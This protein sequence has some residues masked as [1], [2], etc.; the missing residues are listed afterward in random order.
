YSFE[1]S[2][3]FVKQLPKNVTK[4]ELMNHFAAAGQITDINLKFKKN[5]SFRRFAFIGFESEEAANEAFK[6]N[7][8]YI[9][10]SKIIVEQC[11]DLVYL[12]RFVCQSKSI[13]FDWIIFIIKRKKMLMQKVKSKTSNTLLKRKMKFQKEKLDTLMQNPNFIKYLKLN[14]RGTADLVDTLKDKFGDFK[15]EEVKGEESEKVKEEE[16]KEE[17][18]EEEESE[19][20]KEEGSEEEESEPKNQ[21]LANRNISDIEYLQCLI[22]ASAD[23]VAN[24]K[25]KKA[26]KWKTLYTVKVRTRE[27]HT[28][29]EKTGKI[30]TKKLLK[31]FF[32]PLTFSS[33]RIPRKVTSIAYVGFKTER[34][35]KKALE[36]DKSFIGLD[37]NEPHWKVAEH[38]LQKEAE[39]VGDSGKLFV[40]NLWYSITENDLK[41]LFET[42]GPIAEVTLPICKLTQRS[43]GFAHVTFV[44][45]EHAVKAMNELD[46]KDLKGRILHILPSLSNEDEENNK[47]ETSYQKKKKDEQKKNANNWHNWHTLFIGSKTVIDLMSQKDNTSKYEIF[48]DEQGASAAV[49]MAI[50]EAQ[51]VEETKKTLEENGVSL[52]AFSKTNVQRSSQV[53]LVKNLPA[54]TA[55]TELKEVFGKYGNLG[56][57]VLPPSGV[58]AIIEFLNPSE[59]KEA[60][61]ELAYSRFKYLPL[62]LEWAPFEVFTSPAGKISPEKKIEK[63]KKNVEEKSP[64][65]NTTL[66]VKN[67]NFKTDEETLKTHFSKI[68]EVCSV[69]IAKRRMLSQG[70][71]FVQF[72]KTYDADQ[73]L[74]VLQNSI[75][76]GHNLLIKK[77]EKKLVSR[78]SKLSKMVAKPGDPIEPKILIRNIPFQATYKEIKDLFE[79]TGIVKLL[80]LPRKVGSTEHRG[81]GFI[82]FVTMEEA[83]NA[84]TSLGASTHLYGRRLVLE[85]A[86][87]D[88]TVEQLRLKTAEKFLASAPPKKKLK[89]ATNNEVGAL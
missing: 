39:P 88:E 78:D 47:E 61:K 22:K 37:N 57:V 81:F 52:E 6:F 18:S 41:E 20:V 12:Y 73:A 14:K 42:I 40:R 10:T 38:K 84:M 79:T 65:E 50:N 11:L 74:R 44:F 72:F 2:R 58:T 26:N 4:E 71:G 30:F 7:N 83:K 67:M 45:P 60:F 76:D 9:K 63:T 54:K 48:E 56:R 77:S 8:T 31:D 64:E 87:E 29:K 59:A 55:A 13:D 51:I 49:S 17:G 68:G 35:M 5:G 36:K 3:I 62:Y 24:E 43:K 21:S 32:R 15:Q 46:G 25:E 53:I 33:L 23:E 89:L 27:R 1:M 75:L 80:R 85:W 66:Y 69:M 34:N 16:L 86:N 82:E 19:E 28:S 70:Y